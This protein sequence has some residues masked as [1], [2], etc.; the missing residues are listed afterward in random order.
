VAD[1]AFGGVHAVYV[2]RDGKVI[3]AAD[4]RRDGVAVKQ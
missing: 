3:G 4:P 2:R 1:I